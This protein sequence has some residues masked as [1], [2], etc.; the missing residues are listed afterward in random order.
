[1][2][3]AAIITHGTR[4][5]NEN[6]F[7]PFACYRLAVRVPEIALLKRSFVVISETRE[8]FGDVV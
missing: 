4:I 1:M 6:D 2:D 5:V 8:R 3:I 7:L